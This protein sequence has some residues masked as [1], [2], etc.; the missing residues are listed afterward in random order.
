MNMNTFIETPRLLVK[1]P[2]EIDFELLTL[3]IEPITYLNLKV[4]K[5]GEEMY[6]RSNPIWKSNYFREES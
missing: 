5:I 4:V 2:S 1:S 6:S 3:A